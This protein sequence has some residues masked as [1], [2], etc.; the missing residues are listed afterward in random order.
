MENREYYIY[1]HIRL[2]TNEVFY[3]G[4]AVKKNIKH[5]AF[6]S[7]YGRAFKK[8]KTCRSVYW[9]RIVNKCE[10]KVEIIADNL[11]FEE[12][13]YKEIEFISLYGRRDLG[14]GTL[15][16]LTDG[17]EGCQ[18]FKMS[19]EQKEKISKGLKGKYAS[20]KHHFFGKSFTEEHKNNIAK[21]QI[22]SI[23]SE[24][25]KKK[26]SD[27]QK[28]RFEN[29]ENHPMYGKPRPKESVEKMSKTKREKFANGETV[30]WCKG[31][32]RTDINGE[33]HPK[34]KKI[35]NTKTMQIFN[36]A[37]EASEEYCKEVN[38]KISYS[39][40][41]EKIRGRKNRVV[42]NN[43]DYMYLEDYNKLNIENK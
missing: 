36:C 29:K 12:A 7:E 37:K 1:R 40:F 32:K 39:T 15:V 16:N 14:L 38:K 20:E 3:I 25:T 6:K 5:R 9:Y 34:A 17:G 31:I 23:K 2:D 35:I 33:N 41:M 10:Y 19:N 22:G 8:S 30:C 11:T 43:T 27:A 26:L 21:S 18:G 42:K 24:E 28:K 4:Q 13:N